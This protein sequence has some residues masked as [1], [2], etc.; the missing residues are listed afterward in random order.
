MHTQKTLM[1]LFMC[2][3]MVMTSV[4]CG[5]KEDP[6]QAC[7]AQKLAQAGKTAGDTEAVAEAKRACLTA[8]PTVKEPTITGY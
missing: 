2:A 5:Q 4:A 7:V 1:R 6:F 3:F 8:M